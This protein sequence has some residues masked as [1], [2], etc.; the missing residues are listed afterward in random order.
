[1][2]IIS[3]TM[4]R[5]NR[6]MVRSVNVEFGHRLYLTGIGTEVTVAELREFLKKY[7]QKD[8]DW[9]NRV[10]LNTSRPAYVIAFQGLRDGDLQQ[11][12]ER[13]NGVYW[14]AHQINAH[15]I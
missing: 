6:E 15:V 12:A 8:P 3:G 2:P 5:R 10:D 11:F 9:V 4:L 1:M 13:I 7:T 14:Q